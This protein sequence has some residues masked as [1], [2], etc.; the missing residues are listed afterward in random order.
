MRVRDLRCAGVMHLNRLGPTKPVTKDR[1]P[2]DFIM[3][4]NAA[5]VGLSL[6]CRVRGATRIHAEMWLGRF[7]RSQ[8]TSVSVRHGV[9][10]MCNIAQHA[11]RGCP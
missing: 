3:D 5:S 10:S 1:R 7:S 6:Q 4:G 8:G 9:G 2:C 11:L